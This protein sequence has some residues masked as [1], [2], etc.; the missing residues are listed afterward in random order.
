MPSLTQ[1][2]AW[3]AIDTAVAEI[4]GLP[5]D[6]KS[7]ILGVAVGGDLARGDFIPNH[8]QATVLPLFSNA[9][10]LCIYHTPA[11]AAYREAFDN[12][13][14]PFAGRTPAPVAWDSCE[15][16]ELHVP[17]ELSRVCYAGPGPLYFGLWLFDL[18][19]NYRIVLG[20]DYVKEL[21]EFDP[22]GATAAHIA[23][24]FSKVLREQPRGKTPFH[25]AISLYCWQ[26]IITLQLH[27]SPD[28]TLHNR[29]VLSNLKEHVPDFPSK[30][31]AL[32]FWRAYL[33]ARY[34]DRPHRVSRNG[35][36]EQCVQ[37]VRDAAELVRQSM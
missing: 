16:D 4:E 8:S 22:R 9:E 10:G 36:V 25:G 7:Q 20:R 17:T 19:E 11:Y 23:S 35:A 6:L 18:K 32:R 5:D 28:P 34:P 1:R 26:A 14:A 31:F 27:F 15:T 30:P 37:V 33:N 21:V 12:A 3:K 13:F 24:L 2:A 29:R